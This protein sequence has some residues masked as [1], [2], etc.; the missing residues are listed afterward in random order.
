M[1]STN[2]AGPID[3]LLLEFDPS[4]ADGSAAAALRDL[5]DQGIVRLYDLVVIAKAADGT[6]SAVEVTDA[7][8]DS[9]G[10]FGAFAGARSGLVDDEDIAEAGAALEPG[11]AAALL[12][13]ENSW[14]IPFIAAAR[15]VDAEVVASARIPAD[16]IVAALDALDAA[17]PQN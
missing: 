17:D 8:A 7:G 5:I 3:F 1:T 2:V 11:R 14:A 15:A 13:Y 6:V 12:V 16:Q 10:G 4:K 9:H